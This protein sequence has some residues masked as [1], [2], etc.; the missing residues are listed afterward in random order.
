[1]PRWLALALSALIG[2]VSISPAH[3]AEFQLR[4][5]TVAIPGSA[6]FDTVQA[7]FARAIEAA[8]RGAIE[9][10]MQPVGGTN[11]STELL[12]RLE[13]GE[14]DII[15]TAQGYSPGRFPQTAVME[16]PF[17]FETAAAGTKVLQQLLRER[18]LDRDYELVQPLAL[19][20]TPQYGIFLVNKPITEIADL[21]ALRVRV[22]SVTI[23]QVM[24]RLGMLP[25]VQPYDRVFELL[26]AKGADALAFGWDTLEAARG[27]GGEALSARV[28]G[29][30]DLAITAP[31]TMMIANKRKWSE[32]PRELQI[33]IETQ[34]RASMLADAV[35][36]D[37]ASA[38]AR[39]RLIEDASVPLFHPTASQLADVD[40]MTE[41]VVKEWIELL[42][43]RGMDGDRLYARARVLSQGAK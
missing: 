5:A 32:L 16:L 20:A 25:S 13:R 39:Q 34:A 24:T 22:P 43:R 17:M 42:R 18:L 36:R 9:V 19:A 14:V 28:K 7:P 37:L 26:D 31:T 33:M 15:A 3:A 40:R 8:S 41:P 27:P 1:M 38:A 10:A 11:A 29:I 12:K 21:R 23:G 6:T 30:V 4:F 2:P 35:R